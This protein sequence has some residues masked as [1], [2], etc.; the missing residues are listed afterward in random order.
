MVRDG[1]VRELDRFDNNAADEAADFGR[2][3]NFAGVCGRWDPVILALHRFFIAIFWA[4]VCHVDGHGIARDPL[5]WSAG[6]LPKRRG[7]VHAVRDDAFLPGPAGMWES[8]W[9][10]LGSAPVTADDVEVWPYSVG[11]FG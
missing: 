3:R 9:I 4:V 8:E 5:V 6:A 7:V 2:R 10:A 1:E 11:F